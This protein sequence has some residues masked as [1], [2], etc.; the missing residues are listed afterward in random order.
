MSSL[1]HSTL[2]T[3]QVPPTG[4][5]QP[6]S[7]KFGLCGIRVVMIDGEPWFVATD[8]CIAL[9][10]D[11]TAIR[12]LDDDEKGVYLMHTPGGEQKIA[13]V[14]ESGLYILILRCRDAVKPGTVPHRFR[15]WVTSEV[16]PSLRKTGSYS[17]PL[18][19]KRA[20]A[21]AT[22][23]AS[24]ASQTVFNAV[25]SGNEEEQYSRWIFHL[26]SD[27]D[28]NPTIAHAKPVDRRSYVV[29]LPRL[30]ELITTPDW[31][32][33]T[34]ELLALSEACFQRLRRKLDVPAIGGAA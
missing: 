4:Q 7:F 31:P 32:C 16:L 28:G 8:V 14:S 22:Q 27:Q 29:T 23:V 34:E 9:G 5:G 17:D 33:R 24:V 19:V 30:A 10:I 3:Q 6:L 18:Q 2:S 26:D 13:I 21:L 1:Q 12:R 11:R 20:H 25:M 15:K